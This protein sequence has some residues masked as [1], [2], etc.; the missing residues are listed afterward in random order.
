MAFSRESGSASRSHPWA[1]L[2]WLAE[3]SAT[4]WINIISVI[5]IKSALLC[6]APG[7]VPKLQ[8][9]GRRSP[10]AIYQAHNLL[11]WVFKVL[12]CQGQSGLS[13]KWSSR[14]VGSPS[15]S[16]TRGQTHFWKFHV[17]YSRPLT[18]RRVGTGVEKGG[19]GQMGVMVPMP[20]S[21]GWGHNTNK[22]PRAKIRHDATFD[23]CIELRLRHEKQKISST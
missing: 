17:N 5:N 22:C 8:G 21:L 12:F 11:W 20:P 10:L 13:N 16:G 6:F 4:A 1:V 19:G 9:P 2:G 23:W 14:V 15:V 3:G 18:R 7:G